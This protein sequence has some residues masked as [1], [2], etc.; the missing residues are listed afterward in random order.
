[1]VAG[2]RRQVIK[3][4]KD[5]E[6]FDIGLLTNA[7]CLSEGVDVPSL[8]GVAFVEPRSS[9]VDIIQ[10]VG[11]AIRKSDNKQR[12]NSSSSVFSRW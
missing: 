5:L 6:G 11:R 4:L 1:M 12:N 9:Q 7:K 8:D 10:S 3:Q 2:K